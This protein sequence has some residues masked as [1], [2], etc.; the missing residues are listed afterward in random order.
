MNMG[1]DDG[2]DI[3]APPSL[4]ETGC[5]YFGTAAT[6]GL[7]SMCYRDHLAKEAEAKTAME[8]ITLMA[9]PN[10]RVRVS[11]SADSAVSRDGSPPPAPRAS[12]SCWKCKKKVGVMGFNC[13]CGY[14]YC[15][16]HRH[17][18]VHDCSFDFK[19]QGRRVLAMVNPAVKPDKI[20][21]F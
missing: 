6:K 2:E 18:E 12:D 14:A 1:S 7:C 8:K 11:P 21:R 4:C 3:D 13:R 16:S 15:G 9:L 10:L 17:P 20:L 5:G 19:G